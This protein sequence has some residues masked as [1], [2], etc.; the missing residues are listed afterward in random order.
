MGVDMVM[1]LPARRLPLSRA[2]RPRRR[3]RRTQPRPSRMSAR[4][5]W[6]WWVDLEGPVI[7]PLALTSAPK[8]HRDHT[9]PRRRQTLPTHGPRLSV[10]PRQ[11]LPILNEALAALDTIDEKDINYI[12]KLG[13]PPS[14]IKLVLEVRP[15][16][17][18]ALPLDH[19]STPHRP[20][21]RYVL[22]PRHPRHPAEA[23]AELH[24]V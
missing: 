20:L 2:R 19:H 21:L 3:R 6:Q 11:A 22:R 9:L 23:F 12:K 1:L 17:R 13:N 10:F 15:N 24:H 16:L 14:I 7:I 18:E 8:A 4:P 5:T